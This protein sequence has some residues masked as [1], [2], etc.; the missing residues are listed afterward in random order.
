MNEQSRPPLDRAAL[1]R[2]LTRIANASSEAALHELIDPPTTGA[3]RI[4]ITGAPGTGKST[5]VRALAALSLAQGRRVGVLAVD[6][7]SPYSRGAV[8]GDRVRMK[9]VAA[10]PEFFFRSLASR[11]THDGLADNLAGMLCTMERCHFDELIVE[12]VGVGQTGLAVRALVDCVV[13]VLMPQSGDDVQAMKAGIMEIAD[14]LVVNKS[15]LAGAG[16]VAAQLRDVV[17]LRRPDPDRWIPPVI[18]ASQDDPASQRALAETIDAY[19]AWLLRR[20]NEAARWR[21]RAAY[22]VQSILN[23]RIVELLGTLPPA[24]FDSPLPEVYHEL[25]RRLS[26]D[27]D[28]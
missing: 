6:P 4:G 23:R 17:G 16:L 18:L 2:E 15:D 1:G 20:D 10:H 3:R 28:K 12:T 24:M 14:V 7:T 26:A 5:L 8:L 21:A 11:N 19:F 9:E 13:F 27:L 22:H 25:V